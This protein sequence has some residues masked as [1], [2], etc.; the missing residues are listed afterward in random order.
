MP[1]RSRE[2]TT[3]KTDGRT[4]PSR[5]RGLVPRGVQ[6]DSPGGSSKAMPCACLLGTEPQGHHAGHMTGSVQPLQVDLLVDH[7]IS[8][9]GHL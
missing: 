4:R 2:K 5:H 6:A 7:A 8:L 1:S 3:A 9:A